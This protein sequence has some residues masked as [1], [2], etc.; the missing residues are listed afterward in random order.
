MNRRLGMP[1]VGILRV[2]HYAGQTGTR[3]VETL[4]IHLTDRRQSLRCHN[5]DLP[6]S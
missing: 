3:A 2:G 1:P 4:N 6:G 5:L